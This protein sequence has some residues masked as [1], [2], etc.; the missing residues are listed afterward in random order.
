MIYSGLNSYAQLIDSSA[1]VYLPETLQGTSYGVITTADKA[2]DVS[3]DNTVAGPIIFN[4]G[5]SSRAVSSN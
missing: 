5:L 1:N 3:D 4:F 2:A